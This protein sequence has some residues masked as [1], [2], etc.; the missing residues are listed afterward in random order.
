M[1]ELKKKVN[2]VY[3]WTVEDGKP[4]PPKQDLPQA[5]LFLGNGRRW[6]DVYG[7]DGMHLR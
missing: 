2:E 3:N 1:E 6:Y 7:S 5:G 4:Q